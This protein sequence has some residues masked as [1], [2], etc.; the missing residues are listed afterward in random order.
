LN[1]GLFW[2]LV[3]VLKLKISARSTHTA[4]ALSNNCLQSI[5]LA[6]IHIDQGNHPFHHKHHQSSK[7]K[8][9]GFRHRPEQKMPQRSDKGGGRIRR[10]VA[11]AA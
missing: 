5:T 8:T 9:S 3:S 2:W 10:E 1:L 7:K 11:M 6:I 4:I